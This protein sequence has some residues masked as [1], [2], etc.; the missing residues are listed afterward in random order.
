M[1]QEKSKLANME[2]RI[3]DSSRVL[4]AQDASNEMSPS[5]KAEDVSFFVLVCPVI[6]FQKLR[7]LG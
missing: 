5:V 3:R 2:R 6:L 1:L 7:V 4:S